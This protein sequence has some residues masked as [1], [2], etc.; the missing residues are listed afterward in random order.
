MNSFGKYDLYENWLLGNWRKARSLFRILVPR[1]RFSSSRRNVP[2]FNLYWC[3]WNIRV[4]SDSEPLLVT[5]SPVHRCHLMNRQLHCHHLCLSTPPRESSH[6]IRNN[7]QHGIV[8]T[9]S[10]TRDLSWSNNKLFRIWGTPYTFQVE[11]SRQRTKRLK[12]GSLRKV[13]RTMTW[14]KEH[15][16]KYGLAAS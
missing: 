15:L 8:L 3:L 12:A 5:G 14:A 16:H 6:Y 11:K 4:T 9:F 1:C 7:V 2:K 13:S 10:V